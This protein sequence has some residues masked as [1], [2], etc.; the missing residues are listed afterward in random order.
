MFKSASIQKQKSLSSTNLPVAH[1][2]QIH[3]GAPADLVVAKSVENKSPK[4]VAVSKMLLNLL[5]DTA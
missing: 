3:Q 5:Q 2:Q 4:Q 1:K